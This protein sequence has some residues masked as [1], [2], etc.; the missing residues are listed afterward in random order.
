M[1]FKGAGFIV[2]YPLVVDGEQA[3]GIANEN[4]K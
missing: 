3:V 4:I 2:G 1:S